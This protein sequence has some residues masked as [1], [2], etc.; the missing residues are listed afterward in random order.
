MSDEGI[1][2]GE[3]YRRFSEVLV[4]LD[5]ITR[6]LEEGQFVR[7]DLYLEY[8]KGVVRDF[9]VVNQRLQAVETSKL[10]KTAEER[11]KKLEDTNT[12]LLRLILG[13]VV[14]A[15][16]GAVFAASGGLPK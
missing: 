7:T 6:R 10:D 14:L 11:I 3:L 4:R 1:S 12:W 9:E 16:L 2:T 8:R 13:F 5:G 15:V